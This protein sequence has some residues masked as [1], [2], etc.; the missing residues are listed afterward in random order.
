MQEPSKRLNY[1]LLA[2]A[3]IGVYQSGTSTNQSNFVLS[4]AISDQGTV[5]LSG[6]IYKNNFVL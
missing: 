5:M 3:G 6:M 4:I 2:E 1:S